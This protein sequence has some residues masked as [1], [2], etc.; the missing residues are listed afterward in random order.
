MK[1]IDEA[2]IIIYVEMQDYKNN[3]SNVKLKVE[4]L[5]NVQSIE[6]KPLYLNLEG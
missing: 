4:P 5:D 6:I 1:K 3:P 2:D